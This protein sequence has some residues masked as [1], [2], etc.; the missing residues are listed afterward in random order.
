MV[1]NTETTIL[2][3]G[4]LTVTPTKSLDRTTFPLKNVV[5]CL[6]FYINLISAERAANAGIYHN[7]RN[8]T[9]EE[10]NGTLI[11]QLNTK[12]GIYLI[13]WDESTLTGHPTANHTVLSSPIAHLALTTASHDTASHDTASHDTASHDTASYDTASHDTA[14]HDTASHDTASHNTALYDTASHDA[15]ILYQQITQDLGGGTPTHSINTTVK[16]ISSLISYFKAYKLVNSPYQD[17]RLPLCNIFRINHDHQP[18]RPRKPPE[19]H[20]KNAYLLSYKTLS[21]YLLLFYLIQLSL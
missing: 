10:E 16:D 5:Y 3:Y 2:G 17:S 13:K 11:C 14:S 12:S 6:G 20:V 7:G 4:E 18:N 15:A 8:C 21:S 1:G 19:N 9:L